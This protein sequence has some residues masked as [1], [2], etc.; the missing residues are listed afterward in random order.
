MHL[1]RLHALAFCAVGATACD[2]CAIST[3]NRAR[4]S[5]T[6]W[7][8]GLAEQ[9]THFG[10][11]REDGRA[12]SDDSGQRLDSSITQLSIGYRFDP[13]IDVQVV[14]PYIARRFR[15]P[16]GFATDRGTERGLGDISAIATW[17]PIRCNGVD[18]TAIASL[19]GGIELP[20]GDTD[21]LEEEEHEE[22]IPGAPESGIH[23]H[24]LAL[25]S[26]SWDSI[27]GASTYLALRRAFVTAEVQYALRSTG[28]HDYRYADDLT[29]S[30]APGWYVL[31]EHAFTA[32]LQARLTGEHKGKD[33][34]NGETAEDTGVTSLWLGPEATFTWTEHALVS[35]G[36]DLPVHQD[37][38]ALQ[39]VPDYRLRAAAVARF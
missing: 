29:W 32:A 11:L 13:A 25:G 35:A 6:G 12:V 19:F 9:F 20:T 17:T 27:V 5:R 8:L 10:T 31:L 33:S 1:V 14:V 7:H 16:E 3:A 21:R 38:T 28:D 39:I 23:G 26:G 4:D 24:D 36:I 2:F 34:H 15:R 18:S 37:T 30:I 22:E